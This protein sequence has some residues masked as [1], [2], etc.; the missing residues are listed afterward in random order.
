MAIDLVTAAFDVLA[1]VMYRSESTSTMFYL[2]SFLINKV[3]IILSQIAS[4]IFTMTVEMCIT[5]ALSHVDPHAFPSFSQGFDDI[6][7]SNNSLS[8][9]RQDFLNACALHG[10]IQ[11]GSVERLLGEAPMQGPPEKRYERKE[12]LSQ[13]KNNF[14]KVSGYIDE[15]DNLDGNA[16]AIVGAVTDVGHSFG[17]H[18][19]KPADA[20]IVHIAP[21]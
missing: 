8:D 5:Q 4:S 7:G 16:G 15:L 11:A 9:V 13:C 21:V 18:E 19:G 3:P 6:M 10:L 20:I 14:D 1:N 12:L 17:D 2:K